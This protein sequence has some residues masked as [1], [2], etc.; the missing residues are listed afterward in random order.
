VNPDS[1]LADMDWTGVSNK[2]Y[3]FKNP[4]DDITFEVTTNSKASILKHQDRAEVDIVI[5]YDAFSVEDLKLIN[6]N[7]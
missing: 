4:T 6:G 7:L 2:P 1:V 3:D 5:T